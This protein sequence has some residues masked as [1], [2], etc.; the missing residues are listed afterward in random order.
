MIDRGLLE[1]IGPFGLI[2]IFSKIT[3]NNS[4]LQSGFIYHYALIMIIGLSSFIVLLYLPEF[5]KNGVLISLYTLFVY[6]IIYPINK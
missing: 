2:Q 6:K 1:Y 4:K 3:K 5:L